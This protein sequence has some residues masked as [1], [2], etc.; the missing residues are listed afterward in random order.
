[1]HAAPRSYHLLLAMLH[2]RIG[3]REYIIMHMCL[4]FSLYGFQCFSV[5]RLPGCLSTFHDM[6][7]PQGWRVDCCSS[8]KMLSPPTLPVINYYYVQ[9]SGQK[10]SGLHAVQC[11]S[12]A[13]CL[14][15]MT[16]G[17]SK[18]SSSSSSK[19]SAVSTHIGV[20]YIW[21]LTQ[22]KATS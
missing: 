19:H 1:M 7:F 14:S 11:S 12:V 20:Q 3:S 22:C 8:V 6:V 4:L 15:L 2:A 17:C 16:E 10:L 13:E 9:C 18:F 21:R 5:Y